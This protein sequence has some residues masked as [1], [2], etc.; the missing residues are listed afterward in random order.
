MLASQSCTSSQD[1]SISTLELFKRHDKHNFWQ[2]E[3]AVSE[4]RGL[5]H[6]AG[7][8]LGALSLYAELLSGPGVLFDEYRGYAEEIRLLAERSNVLIE[9]LAG[10]ARK[11]DSNVES[12]ILPQV[13]NDYKG[14]LARIIKRPIE[15]TIGPYSSY[16]ICVSSEIIERIL[17]NLAKNAAAVTPTAGMISVNIEGSNN[18][19]EDGRHRVVM[20]VRDDGPG[21]SR[22]TQNRLLS[23]SWHPKTYR[24][25]LGL[26][27]VREL[28]AKSGGYVDVDSYPG[29]GTRVSVTWLEKRANAA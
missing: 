18:M 21:M 8:I 10:Y 3:L 17:V 7:N 22:S 23:S 26:R 25:G 19:D 27:I 14:L 16:P 2:E 13:V 29:C 4:G 20:T 9:R 11:L 28:V 6:D 24:R 1:L 5:A 15:V 12:A